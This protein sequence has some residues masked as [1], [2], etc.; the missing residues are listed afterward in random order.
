MAAARPLVARRAAQI[1]LVLFAV[2]ASGLGPAPGV[3]R[4]GWSAEAA[5]TPKSAW[6]ETQDKTGTTAASEQA[7]ELALRWLVEHQYPNGG[8]SFDHRMSRCQGRCSDPGSMAKAVNGA[9]GL[10]VLPLIC[11]GNTHRAG[12]YRDQVTAGLRF[13]ISRIG[14]DG[15][16]LEEGGTMYS[17]ALALWALC[18]NCRIAAETP[19][20][21]A[22]TTAVPNDTPPPAEPTP[23]AREANKPL[24]GSGARPPRGKPQE[25]SP[26][27]NRAPPDTAT[28]NLTPDEA[29]TAL[30]RAAATN[31]LAY[32][33]NA[34]DPSSGGWRYQPRQRG[35][36]SVTGWQVV[37]LYSAT[38]ADFPVPP[39]ASL[40]VT[41]FLNSVQSD[42]GAT[43]GYLRPTPTPVCSSI[44]LLCRIYTGWEREQPGLQAGATLLA[45]HGPSEQDM[46]Y[47]YYA[48]L[49]L[50]HVGGP[51]WD[52]WNVKL[53]E[54]LIRTQSRE[55]HQAGSWSFRGSHG[56]GAGGRLYNTALACLILQ[57]PYRSKS[58]Y[59]PAPP[60]PPPPPGQ[61]PEPK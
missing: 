33:L 16:F 25:R 55:G 58:M 35:D 15:S 57:T 5:L 13:L 44:G 14:P 53:R 6:L 20:L 42:Y 39:Q 19:G 60:N 4:R 18:E 37:A 21:A 36:T 8:W 40:G 56:S 41:G 26:A 7:V 47:N 28:P 50:H 48:T 11:H 59:E 52:D 46:Y 34:Q 49:V 1:P 27:L 45:R 9:T 12:P 32:T 2:A 38:K 31:A 17:H 22:G 23:S 24:R 61:Q 43:Y 10:A 3:V 54:Y 30:I 51:L 29:A